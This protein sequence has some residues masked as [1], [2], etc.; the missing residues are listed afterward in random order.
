[1]LSMMWMRV[2]FMVKYCTLRKVQRWNLCLACQD[3]A[4]DCFFIQTHLA[5]GPLLLCGDLAC[6]DHIH[7]HAR[8]EFAVLVVQC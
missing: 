1:M 2:A 4:G 5:H 6:K 7:G 3:L 8:F